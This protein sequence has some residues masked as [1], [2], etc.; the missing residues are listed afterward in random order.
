[1]VEVFDT[2]LR[3]GHQS[4]IA[5]RFKLEDMIPILEKID[6]VG[7][8]GLEVWGGA[9]FDVCLRFLKEDPWE[10]LRIIRENVKRTKLLMLLRGQNLVG[11]RH[12]SDDV[13]IKFI[14]LAYRN[15]IDIFRVFDALND[16]RNLELSIKTIKKIGGIVRGEM[17][18]TISP[19]H[20]IDY[21]IK[22]AEEL[23]S[24]EVDI[25]SIKDMAGIIDP[26]TT[27]N[28]ITEIK[29]NF[30]IP[31]CLHSHN[32]AGL[33][34]ASYLKAVEAG[35]D[36]IDTAITPLAFG[37]SQPGIETIYY[38]L[39][40]DKRPRI[41]INIVF[42]ISSYLNKV[43]FSKYRD[44]LKIETFIPD[45]NVLIHQ[46]PGGMMSNLI[47]QLRELG[48]EDKLREVLEEVPRVRADLGYP[49]LVTPLS[50]IV[51]TQSVF[52]VIAGRY[53]VVIKEVKDYVKGLY[54]KPPAPISE[55]I[56]KI[57]LGDEKEINTRPADLLESELIKCEEEV[58]KLGIPSTPENIVS[59]CL[60]PNVALEFFRERYRLNNVSESKVDDSVKKQIDE[61]KDDIAKRDI[62]SSGDD[63]DI[64]LNYAQ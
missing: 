56:K 25:I 62:E 51:G 26:I 28:L 24:L 45:V 10:R 9:T 16:V 19:V 11:Y 41:N 60:F 35:V 43:L 40:V 12:Y 3:D 54:G 38:A 59:Y 8:Y 64:L 21:Y 48:A 5:T 52:N 17:C 61:K 2:T 29:K 49:P 44:L 13:V 34:V 30:K 53:R 7:F 4:L 18:Y 58:K 32:T 37:T 47:A 14:E 23:V 20:T 6:K 33:A 15:G 36:Y 55:D 63:E 31:V 57:I 27:Y 50:Q 42:E 1:M 39:P 22:L 46:I